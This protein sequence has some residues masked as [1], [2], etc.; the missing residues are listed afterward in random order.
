[1][2][3]FNDLKV[4]ECLSETQFYKVDKIVGDKVQLTPDN[5]KSIVVDKGY[6]ENH[7]ISASQFISTKQVNKT[8]AAVL[9]TSNANVVMTVNFNKQV[10]D[11][12]V[13]KAIYDLYPNKG[14]LISE[15]DFKKN[16]N[17]IIKGAL[18]GEERTMIGR[19]NGEINELGRLQFIDMQVP[20]GEHPMRQVDPRNLN[21]LI[22]KG[23]K[24]EVK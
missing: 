1:M 20:K 9:L 13:K 21:W 12:D 22:I 24:Y 3:K 23:V 19:H 16:V 7:I 11:S 4:G 17:S 8:E 10:K 14:K 5:G 2:T 6:I 15:A 18:D